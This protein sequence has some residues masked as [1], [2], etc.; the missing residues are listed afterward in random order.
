MPSQAAVPRGPAVG[1]HRAADGVDVQG[2]LLWGLLRPSY[3]C[4]RGPCLRTMGRL[5]LALRTIKG[6][7]SKDPIFPP[8][9]SGHG[10]YFEYD[11]LS[12]FPYFYFP[13]TYTNNVFLLCIYT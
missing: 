13:Y 5:F 10:I 8:C 4:F 11:F 3:G 1:R 6:Q 2:A 7:A 12:D 9:H